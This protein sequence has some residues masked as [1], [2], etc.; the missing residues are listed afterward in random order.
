MTISKHIKRKLA[1]IIVA[2]TVI[3]GMFFANPARFNKASAAENEYSFV[4]DDLK[5]DSSF[6]V[7]NY[8]KT[9]A[10]AEWYSTCSV[11]AVAESINKE[12]FIYVY[13]SAEQNL[14]FQY[15]VIKESDADNAYDLELV[16]YSAQF[17]KLLLKDFKVN[18]E[19]LRNYNIVGFKIKGCVSPFSLNK[20]WTMTTKNNITNCTVSSGTTLNLG[21]IGQD[22]SGVTEFHTAVLDDLKK[23]LCSIGRTK[24]K[25]ERAE[26]DKSKLNRKRV[27]ELPEKVEAKCFKTV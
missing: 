9:S 20:V 6:Y 1:V 13:D 16:S 8:S 22:L 24:I 4:L 26:P 2:I 12:L 10:G 18:D 7:S 21:I 3:V 17:Y 25:S 14:S 5:R 15:V 19:P 23:G 11:I 27:V